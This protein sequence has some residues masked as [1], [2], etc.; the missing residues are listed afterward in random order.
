M[1]LKQLLFIN[2]LLYIAIGIAYT[3]YAPN[4]LAYFG[5]SDLPSGDYL[6]YW[7]IV[8]F[9]RLFGALLFSLGLLLLG[10]RSLVG[11]PGLRPE[12]ARSVV[13]SLVIG[14]IIAAITAFT[15]AAAVWSTALG[16][17]FGGMFSLFA[18]LY[19]YFLWKLSGSKALS[20]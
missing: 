19:G 7:F 20:A 9:A 13:S 8:S 11:E 14:N 12:A 2:A 16:W 17:I 6:T 5:V 4:T 1:K 15:Q 10:V 3:L 18:I